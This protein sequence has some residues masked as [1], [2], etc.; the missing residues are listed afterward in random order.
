MRAIGLVF[1]LVCL[2]TVVLV[3]RGQAP[4]LAED[5][6]YLDEVEDEVQDGVSGDQ[7]YGDEGE[8]ELMEDGEGEIME[9]VGFG[10][11][12]LRKAGKPH[13]QIALKLVN[14]ASF[15][16]DVYWLEMVD[17]VE[18]RRIKQTVKPIRNESETQINS[19]EGHQFL[20]KFF[21]NQT[22]K[23]AH[24]LFSKSGREETITVT[25]DA[26]SDEFAVTS[27]SKFDEI[28]AEIKNATEI[29]A[30]GDMSKITEC[31]TRAVISDIE[32]MTEAKAELVRNRDLMSNRLRNYTCADPHLETTPSLYSYSWDPKDG[33]E[34]IPIDVLYESEHAKIWVA[35]DFI[36]E[37]ECDILEKHGRPELKRATVAAEDG[38]SIVSVHRKA[39]QAN[40][41]VHH[42]DM[43]ND[44]LYALYYRVF[45][46]T[47]AHAGFDLKLDGQ[48][49]FTIIQYNPTD[50]YTPHCDG[51]CDGTKHILH[52]RVASAVL[53]CR[54]ADKGGATSFTKSDVFVKPTEGMGTFFTYKGLDGVMD[55]GYTEHSG[56]PVIKGEKWIT[57]VWMR[58]VRSTPYPCP[59]CLSPLSL[60][61]SRSN[62]T[63]PH[64]NPRTQ[65]GVS[66]EEPWHLYD[67]DGLRMLDEDLE[68]EELSE[69][70]SAEETATEL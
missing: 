58:D 55:D 62:S 3:T 57:T 11:G 32:K 33:G 6:G 47:N 48:E 16:I 54:V 29:C 67:P 19:Y 4:S 56:C 59:P 8:E 65:Q 53:Y 20:V 52:G 40:Y 64:T 41:D 66:T 27:F 22:A 49:D 28:M 5:E 35:H 10:S 69:E 37:D 51:T 36:T 23:D 46:M 13:G 18:K 9:E 21:H 60:Y 26:Q 14:H 50:E 25:Y 15:P 34:E 44:P 2:F 7:L 45:A 43:E 39:Q 1:L 12:H 42:E 24:V 61:F 30:Q 68:R 31:V 38:T 63:S 17:G 70:E